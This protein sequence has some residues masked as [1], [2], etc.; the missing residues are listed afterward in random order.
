MSGN[1]RLD[2]VILLFDSYSLDSRR[3]HTSFKRAECDHIAVAIEDDGFLPADVMSVYGFFTG[4]G[5]WKRDNTEG[6][7]YFNEVMIPS[8]LRADGRQNVDASCREKDWYYGERGKIFYAGAVRKRQVKAVNWYDERDVVRSKDHYN[9]HG[10]LYA[11]TSFDTE[12]RGVKKTWFSPEG[13]EIIEEDLIGGEITLYEGNDIKCFERKRDLVVYFFIKTGYW[14]KRIFFNSLSTP[15]FVSNQLKPLRKRDVLFWQESVR[16]EIPGNMRMILEGQAR[17]TEE[18]IVQR[19]CSYDRLLDL[20][21]DSAKMHRLGLIYR[22]RKENG[23]RAEALICTNSEN[24]E[25]CREIV[26]VLPKMHFHIAALTAM[27]PKLLSMGKYEN[28]SLYPGAGMDVIK[29][30]FQKCDYYLDINHA[31][32]IVSA[33]Y[34]AFLHNQFILAFEE[35]VH[36]RDYVAE[37][38]IYPV[39]EWERMVDDVQEIMEN[40]ELLERCLE[41]QREEALAEDAGAYVRMM[42]AEVERCV[43]FEW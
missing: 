40:E 25:H 20:G 36:N 23:H 29:E 11:R 5:Q 33:V 42:E 12:G 27:S 18:I 38:W 7:R 34:R 31:G 3:L 9:Q 32:E 43:E 16:E 14:Q 13:K 39:K 1:T 37:R 19:K 10:R 22:F 2:E 6:K 15:F 24:V 35:T 8:G 17:R 41:R 21:V 30:L 28:V 4:D 26:D